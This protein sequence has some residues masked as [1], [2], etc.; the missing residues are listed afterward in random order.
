[1]NL[2][3]HLAF[4]SQNSQGFPTILLYIVTLIEGLNGA[5]NFFLLEFSVF[6]VRNDMLNYTL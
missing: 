2:A 4:A 5:L 3:D 1:M 6:Y